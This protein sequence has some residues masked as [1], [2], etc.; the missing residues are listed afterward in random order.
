MMAVTLCGIVALSPP[1]RTSA[2]EIS[3]VYNG[4]R[5]LTADETKF[6]DYDCD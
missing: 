3:N 4:Y 5:F 6:F 1:Y 2:T